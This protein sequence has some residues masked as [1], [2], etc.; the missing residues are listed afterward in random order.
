MVNRPK[1]SYVVSMT[2]TIEGTDELDAILIFQERIKK[3]YYDDS[4][5]QVSK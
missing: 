4:D 3:D 2:D 5:F 1:I